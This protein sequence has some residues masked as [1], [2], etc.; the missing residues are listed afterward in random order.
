[1]G[2][3]TLNID[4]KTSNGI[5]ILAKMRYFVPIHILR[6]L[7]FAFIAPRVNYGIINWVGATTTATKHIQSNLN[8]TLRRKNFDKF[9]A[10][11]KPLFHQMGILDFQEVINFECAKLAFDITNGNQGVIR[12]NCFENITSR[13]CYQTRQ[14]TEKHL[15]SPIMRTNY[16]KVSVHTMALKTGTAYLSISES[17]IAKIVFA[18]TSKNGCCTNKKTKNKFLYINIIE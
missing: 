4:M 16:K 14:S 8:K 1:M 11:T 10:S 13:H 12:D 5:G 3:I 17:K 18:N 15:A 6:N 7:Y 9:T 2:N